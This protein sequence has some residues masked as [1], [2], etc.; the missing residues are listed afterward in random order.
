MAFL[1]V[2]LT[3]SLIAWYM[4]WRCPNRPGWFSLRIQ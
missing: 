3:A 1:K 2:E 4:P